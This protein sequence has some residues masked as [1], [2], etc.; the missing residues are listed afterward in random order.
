VDDVL[1][2]NQSQHRYYGVHDVNNQPS[3]A[4]TPLEYT[5]NHH[6]NPGSIPSHEQL[7]EASAS[8]LHDGYSVDSQTVHFDYHAPIANVYSPYG[9][10]VDP[11]IVSP[12]ENGIHHAEGFVTYA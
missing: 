8:H 2:T 9:S 5:D 6:Y 10:A 4:A 1:A 11:S 12:L 3:A 7:Y